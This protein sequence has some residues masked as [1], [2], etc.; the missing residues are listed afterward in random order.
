MPEARSTLTSL[1]LTSTEA[2]L[3]MA[4]VRYPSVSVSDLAR[5][6]AIKRP[7]IYHALSTLKTKG[8]VAEHAALGKSKFVMSPPKQLKKLLAIQQQKID[9]HEA[10]LQKIIPVLTSQIATKDSGVTT[11]QYDGIEGIK[12]TVDMALYCRNRKW[13][14][15]APVVNFFSEFDA[16]YARYYLDTRK[17]RQ[18]IS[19]TLWETKKNPGGRLTP[20]DIRRRQPRIMPQSMQGKFKSVLILFDDKVAII[21]SLEKLSSIVISSQEVHDLFAAMFDGI[22]EISTEY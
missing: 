5:E 15:I 8:L 12:T 13:D 14:V 21:S 4:G 9:Q 18:I 6:T 10:S 19:R 17:K 1:G 7:T 2:D 22:W 20:E 16:E 11:A 3:Y